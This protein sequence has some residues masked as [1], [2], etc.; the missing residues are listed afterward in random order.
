MASSVIGTPALRRRP[1]TRGR[2]GTGAD[3]SRLAWMPSLRPRTFLLEP[4]PTM[5][6][7]RPRADGT[8]NPTPTRSTGRGFTSA[9]TSRP[10]SAASTARRA[11]GFGLL[12][13][14]LSQTFRLAMVD[15]SEQAVHAL[16]AWRWPTPRARG[17]APM[18][19]NTGRARSRPTMRR[20]MSSTHAGFRDRR[21]HAQ[22]VSRLTVSVP[23]I[24]RVTSIPQ[25]HADSCGVEP[26]H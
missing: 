19:S 15:S 9:N 24:H 17:S 23:S 5:K 3:R 25:I 6:V 26:F 21:S 22:T 2:T 16:D 20:T 4:D 11:H 13:G 14:G 18:D 10:S 12:Y 7:T 8:K 1:G